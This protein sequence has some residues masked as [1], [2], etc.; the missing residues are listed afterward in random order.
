MSLINPLCEN[1]NSC[2]I[3]TYT[4]S[5]HCV[6]Y[7]RV[8][9]QWYS[10]QCRGSF[11]VH[12]DA[13]V[14]DCAWGLYKHWTALKVDYGR[15]SLATHTSESNTHW[16]CNKH[17]GWTLYQ[18]LCCFA[19]SGR[20]FGYYLE[21]VGYYLGKIGYYLWRVNTSVHPTEIDIYIYMCVCCLRNSSSSVCI[22]E[23]ATTHK[24]CVKLS[25]FSIFSSVFF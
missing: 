5:Y 24:Q 8:S 14:C 6:Q 20:E 22:E 2:K 1:C 18:L 19:F 17:F 12:I 16:Y 21:R 7:F 3:S 23:S 15:K 13:D 10:C 4:H 9:K 25:L 11:N